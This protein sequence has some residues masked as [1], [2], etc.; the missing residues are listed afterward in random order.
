MTKKKIGLP[1]WKTGDNSIGST[2]AYIMFA[3]QYGEVVPLMPQ[4]T[5]RTDLDL[6]ILPGG[7]DINPL[8]Y[9][10]N[11]GYY[12]SKPDLQ[13]DYFDKVYLPQYIANGTPI[14]GICRGFQT[15]GILEGGKLHQNMSHETNKPEDPYKCVHAIQLDNI[16]FWNW[17]EFTNKSVIQTNSRHHQ[18]IDGR[19]LSDQFTVIGRHKDDGTIEMIAHNTLAISGIQGHPEDIYDNDTNNFIDNV[20]NKLIIT[21]KSILNV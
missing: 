6:L 18:A 16:N 12:T 17:R 21:R 9:D 11:P 1:F 10:E 8:M 2:L 19:F 3:E 20:I 14:F 4:H 15:L 5:I 7:P 13:K